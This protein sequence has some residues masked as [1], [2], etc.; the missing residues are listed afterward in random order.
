MCGWIKLHRKIA[1]WEW[2]Q[3]GPTARVFLHLLLHANHRAKRWRGHVIG[4]G[5]VVTSRRTL[6][7]ELGL[8]E[9][10]VRTC[11]QKLEA[12]HET[13]HKTTHRFSIIT[14]CNFE[15]YQTSTP[16][17]RPTDR[18]TDR[19]ASDPLKIV[20]NKP[21]SPNKKHQ[22]DPLATTTKNKIL[23][24]NVSN[25]IK[26]SKVEGGSRGETIFKKTSITQEQLT[27]IIKDPD[28]GA[29]DALWVRRQLASMQDHFD[30]KRMRNWNAV[31]RNWC[32][33]AR[34]QFKDQP[35]VSLVTLFEEEEA[36]GNQD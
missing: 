5:Q 29:G 17:E 31:L 8:S 12:T 34:Y 20:S 1:D 33:R 14:I 27:A 15:Q 3:D 22:N 10:K 36:N 35:A 21:K 23:S 25:N 13:T 28:L 24:S 32:R 9:R 19:P 11:L 2:Y 16:P 26:L 30:G 4:R 6:A 18:P 7:K